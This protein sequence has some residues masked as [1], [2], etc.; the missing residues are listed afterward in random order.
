MEVHVGCSGWFY[1]HWRGIFYPDTER[2]DR[3]FSI[4]YTNSKLSS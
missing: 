4:M 3:W 2:T 1:R